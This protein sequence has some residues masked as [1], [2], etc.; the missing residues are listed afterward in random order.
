MATNTKPLQALS[1]S[2]KQKKD[3]DGHSK[4]GKENVEFFI[5]C[6]DFST[7]DGRKEQI[8]KNYQIYNNKLPEEWFHYVTNP[9]NS[10]REE[11]KNFPARIRPYNILRPNVDLYMGEFIKKAFTFQVINLSEDAFNYHQEKLGKALYQN[12]YQRYINELNELGIDTGE[13]SE[14]V[15]LPQEVEE[16]FNKKYQDIRAKKGQDRLEALEGEKNFFH[17]YKRLFLDYIIAGEAY[18]Y[19]DVSRGDLDYERVSPLD[20]DF[21]IAPDKEYVE[22]ADWVVRRKICSAADVV[23]KFYDNVKFK[24]EHLDYLD[25]DTDYRFNSRED[26]FNR[27][28]GEEENLSE[29]VVL[30]H[31]VW[32]SRKKIG[33]FSYRDELGQP[34]EE[35]VEEGFKIPEEIKAIPEM[36]ATVT[37]MWVNEYWEGYKL[38]DEF[39]FDIQPIPIQRNAL[40]NFSY[41][42]NPY[43]GFKY[44]NTHAENISIVDLGIPYQVLFVIINY[45]IERTI[46]K[47]K[48]K[49]ALLDYN[50]IPDNEDWD[51][52][53]F[54]YYSEAMG[55]ALIDRNKIGVDKSYNQYQVLD[56]S[57]F[58]HISQLIAIKENIRSDFDELLGITRQR[59]GQTQGSDTMGGNER[60]AFQSSIMSELLFSNFEDFKN[61]EYQGI[62]D[63]SKFLYHEGK[64]G[65]YYRDDLSVEVYNMTPEDIMESELAIK[66]S[67][68][69]KDASDMAQLKQF[70]QAFA[71]NG[72]TPS[73]VFDVIRETSVI[74]LENK[75]KAAEQ[76]TQQQQQQQGQQQTQL[77]EMKSQLSKDLENFRHGL[78]VDFMNQ[79][80]DRLD[81]REIIKGDIELEKAGMEDTNADNSPD[82]LD[83]EDRNIER[84]KVTNQQ[85]KDTS[86]AGLKNK[87]LDI[88][89]EGIQSKERI[90]SNKADTALKVAKENK[91]KYDS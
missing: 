33:I 9:L 68:S 69:P 27:L 14:E 31:V 76:L 34:Q 2:E 84:Q 91:N 75:L 55:Y 81:N 30:Y 21:G 72:A 80:A 77:E 41:C 79:E 38:E 62:L 49:I 48:G 52:E 1:L 40:N 64:K 26:F 89:R 39:Y 60:A 63:I 6:T 10:K 50:V 5:D 4:W 7:R 36:G 32:K 61:V 17:L 53:K 45:H 15:Q 90:E 18:T 29:S 74:G 85:S 70:S 12:V 51:E 19:K 71:Q 20:I 59:K 47:S 35:Q 87:D 22:D 67:T 58:Q 83:V 11:F 46:A 37:W 73:T 88:K 13:E 57:L 23:D 54:F 78:N 66:V 86:E 3:S 28:I 8:L 65:L 44:S 56:M 25:K 42:K 24:K 16:N 43:N 82:I